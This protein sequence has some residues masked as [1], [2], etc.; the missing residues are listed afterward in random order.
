MLGGGSSSLWC[1]TPPRRG[2]K[3][4]S[5]GV[6]L[7]A[8]FAASSAL[9]SDNGVATLGSGALSNVAQWP[10]T[11]CLSSSCNF[12]PTPAPPPEPR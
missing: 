1:S 10:E 12:K 4:D 8:L 2:G 11:P 7:A 3:G 5:V 9:R 6:A